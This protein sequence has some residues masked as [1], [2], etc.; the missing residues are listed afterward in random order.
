[1]SYNEP[2]FWLHKNK[3]LCKKWFFVAPY[4]NSFYITTKQYYNILMSHSFIFIG[5]SGC[6]K[7][8]QAM[9]LIDYLKSQAPQQDILY[10]QTGDLLRK[11][12]SEQ[13]TTEKRSDFVHDRAKALSEHGGL[14]PEFLVVYM[15][16]KKIIEEY[17]E[18]MHIVC[19]GMPRKTHEAAILESVLD[20][21]SIDRPYIINIAVSELWA[22]DRM[23][24]RMRADDTVE[25]I[26]E[27]LS[28]YEKQVVPTIEYYKK[29]KGYKYIEVDGE[30]SIS[31]VYHNIIAK[32]GIL[33]TTG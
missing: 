28:W 18:G 14:I 16:A 21:L 1:M 32:I 4:N 30:Q 10:I 19:D 17:R 26:R 13:E 6:G 11:Y 15:W 24:A 9:M 7:G 22:Q 27:R 12:I 5:R 2:D 31:D 25:S 3:P 23:M 33:P 29:T 8:T 20:F